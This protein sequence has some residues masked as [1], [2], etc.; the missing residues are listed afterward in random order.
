MPHFLY[1]FFEVFIVC[2]CVW[3]AV[4]NFRVWHRCRSLRRRFYARLHFSMAL[5]WGCGALARASWGYYVGWGAGSWWAAMW[6]GL[7]F[8][9]AGIHGLKADTDLQMSTS[10]YWRDI[11]RANTFLTKR[12]LIILAALTS[13]AIV[14]SVIG[15]FFIQPNS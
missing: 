4:N 5:F 13:L 12:S 14:A 15:H 7:W 6:L 11:I 10:H 3:A 8:F 9:G 1:I 2:L